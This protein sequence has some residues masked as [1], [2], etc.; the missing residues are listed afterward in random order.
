MGPAAPV[1]PAKESGALGGDEYC[2]PEN[3]SSS[4][5]ADPAADPPVGPAAPVGPAKESV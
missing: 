1:G 5:A 3:M 4:S 2:A